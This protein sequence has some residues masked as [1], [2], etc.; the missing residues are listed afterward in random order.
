MYNCATVHKYMILFKI[1]VISYCWLHLMGDCWKAVMGDVLL[2]LAELTNFTSFVLVYQELLGN[3]LPSD[4]LNVLRKPCWPWIIGIWFILTF[5]WCCEFEQEER[6]W[7]YTITSNCVFLGIWYWIIPIYRFLKFS[8]VLQDYGFN[9]YCAHE[10]TYVHIS[11]FDLHPDV[12]IVCCQIVN[13]GD[14]SWSTVPIHN[15]CVCACVRVCILLDHI[16]P[17]VN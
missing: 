14:Y 2:F 15:P 4:K 9:E 10:Y 12:G 6:L 7:P 13:Q 16:N 5:Y 1:R 17:I 8:N 3:F 11:S